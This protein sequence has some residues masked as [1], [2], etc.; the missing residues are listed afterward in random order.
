[1]RERIGVVGGDVDL[2]EAP[3]GGAQLDIWV[4][5]LEDRE[6]KA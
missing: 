1:M 5:V 2:A 4:P 6:A 3:S